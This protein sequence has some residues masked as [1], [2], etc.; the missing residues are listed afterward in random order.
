MTKYCLIALIAVAGISGSA[1]NLL[2][3]SSFELQ[4]RVPDL[5]NEILKFYGWNGSG[6]QRDSGFHG[7]KYVQT[8]N[9]SSFA[10]WLEPG[11]YAVSVWMKSDGGAIVRMSLEINN[12]PPHSVAGKKISLTKEWKRYVLKAR[13][14]AAGRYYSDFRT[15]NGAA[16]DMDAVQL[17]KGKISGYS[18][19]YTVEATVR[20]PHDL[21]RVYHIGDSIPVE[22]TYFNQSADR[23]SVKTESAV[24][25][26]FFRDLNRK[27]GTVE[28]R[29]WEVKVVQ[30]RIS[31]GRNGVFRILLSV[32]GTYFSGTTYAVVP[33]PANP[34]QFDMGFP[35]FGFD[36]TICD[37]N[38]E[39]ARKLG[40]KWWRSCGMND[41]TDIS[42]WNR[43]EPE[44]GKFVWR[45]ELIQKLLDNKFNILATFLFTPKWA[46]QAPEGT[47]PGELWRF[48]PADFKDW[49]EF[50]DAY[51]KHNRGKIACYEI[52]NEA[53][54]SFF[55]GGTPEEFLE[56]HTIAKNL[57]RKNDPGAK[58]M[59]GAN[60]LSAG[61]KAWYD[62]FADGGG[63]EG[64]DYYDK[65]YPVT[66]F[67]KQRIEKAG[68]RI[69]QSEFN[70][71]G[72]SIHPAS[73]FGPHEFNRQITRFNLA[74]TRVLSELGEGR[75]GVCYYYLSNDRIMG[76]VRQ[77]FDDIP[78][79]DF[80]GG[81]TTFV[82]AAAV[83]AR[84]LYHTDSLGG[85]ETPSGI[86]GWLFRSRDNGEYVAA[87]YAPYNE[88]DI[89]IGFGKRLPSSVKLVDMQGNAPEMKNG[90]CSLAVPLFLRVPEKEKEAL[91]SAIAKARGIGV[92]PFSLRK[93]FAALGRPLPDVLRGAPLV[94]SGLIYR[95]MPYF[96]F[97]KGNRS[98][99]VLWNDALSSS[100][101]F[102]L[103][104][105]AKKLEIQDVFGQKAENRS[106]NFTLPVPYMITFDGGAGELTGLLKHVKIH[107]LADCSIGTPRFSRGRLSVEIG[108][109]TVNPLSGVLSVEVLS[110]NLKLGM[111]S[112]KFRDL[113]PEKI[114]FQEMTGGTST[115]DEMIDAGGS[116]VYHFPV[117]DFSGGDVVLRIRVKSESG[118]ESS[119]EKTIRT[120]SAGK[121]LAFKRIDG[122]LDDWSLKHKI[123]INH[124]YLGK[125]EGEKDCS[126]TAYAEWDAS[127]LY[128]A[129]EVK[130]DTVNRNYSAAAMWNGDCVELFFN[131]CPDLLF[132][133]SP[134]KTDRFFQVLLGPGVKNGLEQPEVF[135]L[136]TGQFFKA[137]TVR[138]ASSQTNDG[139]VL[140]LA[141]PFSSFQFMG[142]VIK[143]FD[144]LGCDIVINDNDRDRSSLG[145]VRT[146]GGRKSVV[147]WCGGADNYKNV[148]GYGSLILVK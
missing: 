65:H 66:D 115:Y 81:P 132:P 130:D 26:M 83:L 109:N 36:G 138:M 129:V 13:V 140:E 99:A 98:H 122:K 100:V 91:L 136:R 142:G 39:L 128:I 134:E 90:T 116:A 119:A 9:L 71:G 16:F 53:S 74:A 86:T 85:I 139:Y 10:K 59:G 96:I 5:R 70:P 19:K 15:L 79:R 12:R 92:L 88:L 6:V 51:T 84:E 135:V 58:I 47:Q 44:K 118:S 2:D 80:D 49:A 43:V 14:S 147:G 78:L 28:L 50:V 61:S 62:A 57:I 8:K 25:D 126:G 45:D 48:R 37:A 117:V 75:I 93:K 38:I 40:A 133:S 111:S 35:F 1:A 127:Y 27:S 41:N 94:S 73:Q 4:E 87:L 68:V 144:A 17:E 107:G 64:I 104:E 143:P 30:E 56:F 145:N 52:W 77:D 46:A 24:Q 31:A 89:R 42:V 18:P 121:S 54:G 3:N 60:S 102:T 148:S 141:I 21:N 95:K 34:D 67:E 76:M 110:K 120:W 29:P 72:V 103:P 32:D 20:I 7:K 146:K 114:L 63:L 131:P 22:T 124:P 11:E 33:K 125:W 113:R 137:A 112:L 106:L 55:N 23:V 69:W 108:N 123:R 97:E 101:S 82:A 105:S